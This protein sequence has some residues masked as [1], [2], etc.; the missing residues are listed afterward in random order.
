MRIMFASSTA[1]EL[2]KIGFLKLN[3]GG[4]LG[5]ITKC[6]VNIT[7]CRERVRDYVIIS[8]MLSYL[9]HMSCLIQKI[10][11][12]LHSMLCKISFGQVNYLTFY[13]RAFHSPMIKAFD[14]L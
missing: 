6:C 5:H 3:C 13:V 2:P 8:R 11:C 12:Y 4:R 10:L 7:T 1:T 9:L 14:E